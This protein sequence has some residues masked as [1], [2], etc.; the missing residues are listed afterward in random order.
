MVLCHNLVITDRFNNNYCYFNL[1]NFKKTYLTVEEHDS[2]MNFLHGN[3]EDGKS[4]YTKLV[5][6]KQFISTAEIKKYDVL[7]QINYNKIK[8]KNLIYV[9]QRIKI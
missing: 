3:G 7:S 1:I 4:V 9:G 5:A 6:S 2:L 8:N